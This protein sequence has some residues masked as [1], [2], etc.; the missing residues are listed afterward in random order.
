MGAARVPLSAQVRPTSAGHFQ[1]WLQN[2]RPGSASPKLG[3][4]A[5]VATE[6]G[7]RRAPHSQRATSEANVTTLQRGTAAED[8]DVYSGPTWPFLLLTQGYPE[9][10]SQP[11]QA[12]VVCWLH[13]G[14]KEQKRETENISYYFLGLKSV[15]RLTVVELQW[16]TSLFSHLLS[17]S[18]VLFF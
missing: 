13:V 15:L 16:F 11:H 5:R 12:A 1:G 14:G 8:G 17:G 7:N 3:T 10:K 6:G 9:G 2:P 4:N 18:F